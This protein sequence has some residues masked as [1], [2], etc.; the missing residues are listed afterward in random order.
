MV[1]LSVTCFAILRAVVASFY[2]ITIEN[3]VAGENAHNPYHDGHGV[4]V[5]VESEHTCLTTQKRFQSK[6]M[7][8]DFVYSPT[9]RYIRRV[10]A[11]L[12]EVHHLKMASL[13]KSLKRH[14]IKVFEL[15]SICLL[16]PSCFAW[17]VPRHHTADSYLW[18][19]FLFSHWTYL[20]SYPLW[21]V[22]EFTL[23][24]ALPREEAN[25]KVQFKGSL[26]ES[27]K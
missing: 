2:K 21:H 6:D 10:L 1:D 27:L 26:L 5:F 25:L 22:I 8:R 24:T 7:T 20:E 12:P 14:D 19:W 4:H 17:H 13:L 11:R 3:V 9:I 18:L 15:V 16:A 23:T